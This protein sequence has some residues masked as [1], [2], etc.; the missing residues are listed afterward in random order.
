METAVI[1]EFKLA[2][3]TVLPDGRYAGS[4]IARAGSNDSGLSYLA[5]LRLSLKRGSLYDA[6][7]VFLSNPFIVRQLNEING[8]ALMDDEFEDEVD[9]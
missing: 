9:G 8:R 6:L 4:T 1:D 2:C 3:A 5:N 7:G